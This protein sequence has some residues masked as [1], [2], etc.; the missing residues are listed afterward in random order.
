[1]ASDPSGRFAVVWVSSD[2]AH[3]TRCDA[4]TI[5]AYLQTLD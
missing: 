4:T 3:C 2:L 5:T 1:V